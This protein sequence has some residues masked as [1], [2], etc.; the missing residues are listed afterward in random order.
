MQGKIFKLFF[1][2]CS[3]LNGMRNL[4]AQKPMSAPDASGLALFGQTT[5]Q[6]IVA[7]LRQSQA[8]VQDFNGDGEINNKDVVFLFRYVSGGAKEEDESVYDFNGD[9]EVN[10]KDVVELFRFASTR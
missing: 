7:A 4:C 8:Q 5:S 9:K 3:I 1:I 2:A 10:N 6:M